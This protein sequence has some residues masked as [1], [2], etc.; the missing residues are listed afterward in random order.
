[1]IKPQLPE[2]TRLH[3]TMIR[4]SEKTMSLDSKGTIIQDSNSLQ[5]NSSDSASATSSNQNNQTSAYT[6]YLEHLGGFL[7]I[8]KGKRVSK[9]RPEFIIFD[10]Q[11]PGNIAMF[12]LHFLFLPARACSSRVY[13]LHSA[14]CCCCC[15]CCCCWCCGGCFTQLLRISSWLHV[16]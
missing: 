3:C 12:C 10:P 6:L 7:P 11:L 5:S 13:I 9:I 14:F 4:H 15:C 8:L 16:E 2:N 1:V